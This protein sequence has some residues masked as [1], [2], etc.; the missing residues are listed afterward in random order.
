MQFFQFKWNE[1]ENLA[2]HLSKL[3]NLWNELNSGL[4][5][6]DE[7]TLPELLL[8]CKILDILPNEYVSFKSSWLLLGEDK[9]TVDELTTQ[10]FSYER[11]FKSYEKD[12]ATEQEALLVKDRRSKHNFSHKMSSNCNYCHKKGHWVKSCSKWI[13]DGRPPKPNIMIQEKLGLLAQPLP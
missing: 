9:R 10:L 3:K 4:Q 11:E 7:P 12:T 1:N 2:A 13:A 5:N 6:K 8:N